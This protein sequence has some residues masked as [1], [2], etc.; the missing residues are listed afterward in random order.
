MITKIFPF[1]LIVFVSIKGCIV[2]FI[3]YLR[4]ERMELNSCLIHRNKL[5]VLSVP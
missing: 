2:R 5:I 1:L 4:Y 3:G